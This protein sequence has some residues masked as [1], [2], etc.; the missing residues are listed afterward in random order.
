[1]NPE[2]YLKTTVWPF[3]EARKIKERAEKLEQ[4]FENPI[5]DGTDDDDEDVG[6]RDRR[7]RE[8]GEDN[9]DEDEESSEEAE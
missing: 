1:M 3:E 7:Q 8:E 9:S 4:D 5:G 2:E 6:F